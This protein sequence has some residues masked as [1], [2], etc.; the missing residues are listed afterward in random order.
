MFNKYK[1]ETLLTKED[2]HKNN[3]NLYIKRDLVY[4]I[5][6]EEKNDITIKLILND[7]LDYA[8]ELI[9]SLKNKKILN[10]KVYKYNNVNNQIKKENI[11]TKMKKLLEKLF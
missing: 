6:K 4:P 2:F 1:N 9:V 10:E 8:G 11:F 3:H 7:N 5:T